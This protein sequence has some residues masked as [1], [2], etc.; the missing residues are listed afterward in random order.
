MQG[1]RLDCWTEG[2][3]WRSIIRLH[4]KKEEGRGNGAARGRKAGKA[5][6]KGEGPDSVLG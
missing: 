6:G 4:I 5:K 2:W 3:G 1:H